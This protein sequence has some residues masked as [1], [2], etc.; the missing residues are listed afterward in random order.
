VDG[1]WE[2][3]S[4]EADLRKAPGDKGT[5][6]PEN[7]GHYVFAFSRGRFAITQEAEGACGWVYGTYSVHGH[8]MVW[9]V[10]DGGGYGPH[11][12]TN[13]PAERFEYSW[14]RFKDTL[15]LA[16]VPGA[17]SANNFLA[18]PWR[19]IGDDAAHAPLSRRCP[20]PPRGVSAL[21]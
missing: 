2:F 9:D 16:P 4:D 5:V 21:G 19:R 12:A 10:E 6:S 11:D 3:V 8:R 1:A 17:I 20:P 7:W 13:R 14:S 15:Q 18:L